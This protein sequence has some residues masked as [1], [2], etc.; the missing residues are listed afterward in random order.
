MKTPEQDIAAIAGKFDSIKARPGQ[1]RPG[2][3]GARSALTQSRTS[4]LHLKVARMTG[5]QLPPLASGRVQVPGLNFKD[6]P[7]NSADE[8][9]Y[10]DNL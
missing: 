3:A 8:P 7:T 10:L 1:A 5:R 4:L 6:L 2:Q 9:R